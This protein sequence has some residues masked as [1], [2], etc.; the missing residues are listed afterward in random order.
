MVQEAEVSEVDDS[1][2]EAVS[3]SAHVTFVVYR[4]FNTCFVK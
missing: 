1:L 2:G 3:E 4:A